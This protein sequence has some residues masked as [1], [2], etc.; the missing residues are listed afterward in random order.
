MALHALGIEEDGVP[1]HSLVP[2]VMMVMMMMITT[3]YVLDSD[4][5]YIWED[6]AVFYTVLP[7][8]NDY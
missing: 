2:P 1:S 3:N 5:C 4:N 7:H 6:L 8:V